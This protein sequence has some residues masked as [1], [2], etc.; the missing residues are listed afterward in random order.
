[1]ELPL[2]ARAV[3]MAIKRLFHTPNTP[4]EWRNQ[5][6]TFWGR[7]NIWGGQIVWI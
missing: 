6:K 7:K 3:M 1:M 4:E 5:T 2:W